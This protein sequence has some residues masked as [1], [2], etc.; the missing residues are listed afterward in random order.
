MHDVTESPCKMCVCVYMYVFVLC[1][2]MAAIG[3]VFSLVAVISKRSCYL[4]NLGR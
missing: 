2:L 3:C 1:V 4:G